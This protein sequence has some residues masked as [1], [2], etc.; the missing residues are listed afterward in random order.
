MRS[1]KLTT[2]I[3]AAGTLLAL[4]PAG[5]V[6]AH[7]PRI[8]KSHRHANPAGCRITSYA[9]P[10]QVTSGETVQVFGQLTCPSGSVASQAV[11]VYERSA[12]TPGFK[13]IA[14]P[15][16]GADGSYAIVAPAVMT[17]SGFYATSLG[18]RSA[19]HLVK[20]APQV[21]L[22]GPAEGAQIKTGIKNRV[23]FAG[24]VNPGTANPADAG[25]EVM[26]QREGATSNEEWHTIQRFAVV[27]GD[28]SYSLVHT[29]GAAGDANLRVVVRAHGTFTVRG[30]SNT[31]SYEI[32]QNQNPRLTILSSADPVNYGM[33]VTI[34]GVLAGGASQKASQKVT[35]LTRTG[36]TQFA[37]AQDSATNG[38]GEYKFVVPAATANTHYR[39]TIGTINS[40]V[41]Y[42]GVKY[43]LTAGIAASTVVSGQPLTFSGTVTP[44]Q[45]GHEVYLE[46][47]NT[48]GGGY[49][50]VD[51]TSVLTGGTYTLA[52]YVFGSG[53]QV[54][55]IKVPGDPTNQA[56]SSTPF[57]IEVTPA[58]LGTLKPVPQG[59]LPR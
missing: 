2:A 26:L 54:Y 57:T 19:T 16:T 8:H 14:T 17:D 48:F 4:A 51:V 6:A 40:A 36:V 45:V 41:L 39:V 50:V 46:R 7:V 31:L 37:K 27:R 30:I 35:L 22:S 3:V 24:T 34:S 43:I 11:T 47:Q 21:S 18:T 53:K 13:A 12:G 44:A 32:S 52:H 9:E 38:S 42:E 23:T 49:H 58:P 10:H 15:T 56:V 33:P 59:K 1:T 25:A 55:R 20:V 29:F 28:G 5:A